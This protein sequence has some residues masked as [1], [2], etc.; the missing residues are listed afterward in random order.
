MVEERLQTRDRQ[1]NTA[2]VS[3]VICLA[4]GQGNGRTSKD[5]NSPAPNFLFEHEESNKIRSLVKR[6]I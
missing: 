3:I 1:G 2:G 4:L 5:G 6:L